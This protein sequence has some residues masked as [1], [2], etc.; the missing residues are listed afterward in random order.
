MLYS[1]KARYVLLWTPET[2]RI[3]IIKSCQHQSRSN[4]YGHR[5]IH[6]WTN[7]SKGTYVVK[8]G[9][10]YCLNV[11]SQGEIRIKCNLENLDSVRKLYRRIRY[12]DRSKRCT[13]PVGSRYLS[14]QTTWYFISRE[15]IPDTKKSTCT[16]K[17]QAMTSRCL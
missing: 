10:G 4:S 6:R 8:T 2:D 12:F 13:W 9:L 17:G 5:T 16:S 3:R 14:L 7:L 11:R 15:T 1:L